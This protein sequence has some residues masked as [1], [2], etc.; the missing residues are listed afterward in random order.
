MKREGRRKGR[1]RKKSR[2]GVE[3]EMKK[4]S[5]RE[6]MLSEKRRIGGGE[7]AELGKVLLLP[8]QHRSSSSRLV[9]CLCIMYVC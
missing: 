9:L 8:L 2:S 6:V 7:A 1:E 4:V 5:R 3:L